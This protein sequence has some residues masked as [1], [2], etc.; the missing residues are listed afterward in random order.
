M[1]PNAETHPEPVALVG[2]GCRFPGGGNGP[3]RLWALLEEGVDAV[4]P[5][6]ADRWNVDRHHATSWQRPG[7][8][9]PREG[10]FLDRV[11]TFDAAFFGISGRVAEQMD[12]QQRLL[13]E[14]CWEALEDAGI[15]PATLA[16]SRAGVFVGACSQDY[17][18]L[19]TS[20][21]EVEGLGAH[22]ATGMYASILANRLSYAFDLH[23]PSMTVDTACSSSL[24]A[25]DLARRSLALGDSDLALVGGVNLMLTPQGGIALGQ[26]SMLSPDSRS[27][28]FD[29]SAN[30]YVRGEGAGVVVLKPLS[31]ARRDNDRIYAVITGS[32]VNQDGRTQGITVPNGSAQEVNFLAALAEAEV[33][34]RDVGYVEAHGTGTPVGD[35]IEAN[36]LGR[37]LSTG[38]DK[39]R[40]AFVGSIKTNIGHLEGGAGIA[41]LIKAALSVHH[42][43]IP[44]TVHLRT[45]NPEI[46][47]ERWR[48]AVATT[49]L[50]WPSY[51]L[52]AVASVNSFGFGGTNAN[53]VLEEA[54]EHPYAATTAPG[55]VPALIALSADSD[56]ALRLLANEHVRRLEAGPVDLERLGATLALRRTHHAHRLTVAAADATEAANG[57]RSHLDGNPVR[58]VAAGRTAKGR[59]RVAFLFNGQGPQW[60]AMGRTLL[61][62][63]AV[64]R[65]KVLECDALARRHIDWSI[66][67]ALTADEASSPVG[68]TRFLQPMMFAVQVALVE[69]WKS[70]GVEP[71]GVLGH[72]MGEIA[73]AHVSGALDLETALT[74][75][76]RRARVQ[77]KADPSGGM[78]FVA[79]DADRARALCTERPDGP[80]FAAENGPDG[81]T[82]SGRRG[83]LDDLVDEQRAQGVFAKVLRVDCACHSRPYSVWWSRGARSL[84]LDGVWAWVRHDGASQMST[85]RMRYP[86]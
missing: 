73:A 28:A 13:L 82:L 47:F 52:R 35:P 34:P 17:G 36:A 29:A 48:M 24:V 44:P 76:C 37:V 25:V 21:D 1:P 80:W 18:G 66:L 9:T 45:P 85:R 56:A 49:S 70:W 46:D 30:G 22:S 42:R 33:E 83:L 7:R 14:V 15:V 5:V 65:A 69:L 68:R 3:G 23:G 10:G 63:S 67:D 74:V 60:F 50:A 61:E 51:Y 71:D 2:I 81:S 6:P 40:T 20:V 16:G 79:L 72:S 8:M 31:A 4:R 19:Q 77:S 75:I 11:D 41:G 58:G 12:P 62:T 78:A 26:A 64:F 84:L 43:R 59:A 53:V 57:L 38:R 39:A 86:W 27:R 32:A 54:P 55:D